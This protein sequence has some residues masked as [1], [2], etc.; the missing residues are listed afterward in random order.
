MVWIMEN[1]F[2]SAL[3][4]WLMGE[5]SLGEHVMAWKNS[6]RPARQRSGYIPVLGLRLNGEMI[7]PVDVQSPV[8]AADSI[9]LPAP[10]SL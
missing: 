6:G 8:L 7:I 4:A 3:T 1:T 9:G 5:I 10:N 2:S